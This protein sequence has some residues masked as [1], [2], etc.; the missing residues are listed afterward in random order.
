MQGWVSC[1]C[2]ETPPLLSASV[3]LVCV[4][5]LLCCISNRFGKQFASKLSERS[6]TVKVAP[7]TEKSAMKCYWIN[8]ATVFW[9]LNH[10]VCS[11]ISRLGE[12]FLLMLM[13]M[14]NRNLWNKKTSSASTP[15]SFTQVVFQEL[16][17]FGID[18]IIDD[19]ELTKFGNS[20]HQFLPHPQFPFYSFCISL[21]LWIVHLYY[22][23][24]VLSQVA[25]V[26]LMVLNWR[27]TVK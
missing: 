25:P 21:V 16:Q 9:R 20:P 6:K 22:C 2:Q 24:S 26:V 15:E 10:K 5:C 14:G 1:V 27:T 17:P 18:D 4:L 13:G 7:K 8:T 12:I 23:S 19:S 11:K 3:S